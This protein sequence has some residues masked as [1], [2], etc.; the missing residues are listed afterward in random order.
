[1]ESD[2]YLSEAWLTNQYRFNVCYIYKLLSH[3]G[4]MSGY[5]K[6]G[7][8]Y[9]WKNTNGM[10]LEVTTTKKKTGESYTMSISNLNVGDTKQTQFSTKG[11]KIADIPEGQSCG[12][13]MD[14]KD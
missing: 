3:C 9:Y 6:N 13:R 7:D 11:F 10:I 4:L 5:V 2:E 1:M 8:W 14:E 12:P